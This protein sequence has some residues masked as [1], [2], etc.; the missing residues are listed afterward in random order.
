MVRKEN[1]AARARTRPESKSAREL[2]AEGVPP[3]N[4]EAERA[5]LGGILRDNNCLPDVVRK[6]KEDNFYSDKHQRIY[7]AMVEMF[8][9][10]HPIDALTLGEE[11]AK[12]GWLLEIGGA[13]AIVDLYQET[14]TAANVGFYSQIVYEKAVLR[15]LIHTSTEILRDAYD[16][17]SSPDELLAEAEKKLFKILDDRGSG[18]AVNVKSVISRAFDRISHRQSREGGA[19][20]GVPSGFYDLD[21]MTDG[22]QDSELIIVAARPSMGKTA[23]ALN[24]VEHAVV[25]CKMPVL[26]ASLEMSDLELAERLLCSFAQVNGHFLRK[27]RLGSEDMQKLIHAGNELSTAPLFIDDTPG[28]TMLRISATARRLKM[29]EGLRMIVIDYL[30]LIE[31]DDK[32][33]SRQEQ[34]S[35]ISRRLKNL[36][37]E[38]K[39][40]V[41]ALSQL[42]RGVESREGHRPRMSDLRESGSIEQDADVVALLHRDDAY[43]PQDN[44]NT[45]E[46]II[47]KQRNGPVGDVKLR[48]EKAFTRFQNFHHEITPFGEG[49]SADMSF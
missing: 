9:A 21:E 16:S 30:Q 45:A 1:G 10:G 37:R 22:W 25:H 31:A 46:V 34:I 27:G 18:D 19:V 39:V 38:L 3:Q 8:S 29:R 15:N 6:L 12:K 33:V 41:I 5:V 26:F 43:D 7:S 28:Q 40:P 11:L 47:A 23:F 42:N 14:L 44:P 35:T 32:S 24:L 13:A 2:L 4:L 20:A 48:F 36:A 17:T 49:G